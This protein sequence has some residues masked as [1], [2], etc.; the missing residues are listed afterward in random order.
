MKKILSW[1]ACFFLLGGVLAISANAGN[2]TIVLFAEGMNCPCR[3][4]VVAPPPPPP[5]SA[6]SKYYGG[7][8]LFGLTKHL[9]DG[10]NN[11]TTYS[12]SDGSTLRDIDDATEKFDFGGARLTIG[13]ALDER[14]AVELSLM[15]FSHEGASHIM[16]QGQFLSAAALRSPGSFINFNGN[17]EDAFSQTVNYDTNMIS[18]ELN[19]RRKLNQIFSM[20]A[21]A[22]YVH[23]DDEMQLTS[24][25]EPGVNFGT[26]NIDGSNNLIGLQVG[27][28]GAIPVASE[29]AVT[30]GVKGGAFINAASIDSRIADDVGASYQFDDTDVRGS[31]ILDTNVALTWT[32]D[33]NVNISLGYMM[34]L[35]SWVTTAGENYPQ[36][37]TAEEYQQ[38]ESDHLL[39]HGPMVRIDMNFF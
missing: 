16:D 12:T 10:G 26:H 30:G 38:H 19:L 22:R 9:L 23:L 35:F 33:S 36:S 34:S 2:S 31:T 21:G 7:L 18:V 17:F 25:D 37:N 27:I 32:A 6:P 24:E 1:G 4:E 13:R 14:D 28:D 3:A 20:I 11:V 8:E 15:G 5:P 39:V 29:L